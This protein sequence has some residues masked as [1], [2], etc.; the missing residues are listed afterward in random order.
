[1]C[2]V[3]SGGEGELD[4]R[5]LMETQGLTYRPT[6]IVSFS[7]D[8]GS[9]GALAS[10]PRPTST[11]KDGAAE[12]YHAPAGLAAASG[13]TEVVAMAEVSMA[14]LLCIYSNSDLHVGVCV[15]LK[16]DVLLMV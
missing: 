7:S 14:G 1:M 16:A 13:V 5:A 8:C 2:T 9:V 10:S 4:V 15:C 11:A 12:D 3:S 6:S